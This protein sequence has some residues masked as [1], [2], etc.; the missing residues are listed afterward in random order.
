MDATDARIAALE[1]EH[2]ALKEEYTAMNEQYTAELARE[3][4]AGALNQQLQDCERQAAAVEAAIAQQL[5]RNA[6][7]ED[8]LSKHSMEDVHEQLRVVRVCLHPPASIAI[9]L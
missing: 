7:I 1:A 9:I 8:F 3:A 6:D 5:T 2:A 4:E